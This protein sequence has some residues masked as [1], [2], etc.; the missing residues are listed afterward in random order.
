ME[1][2]LDYSKWRAGGGSMQHKNENM[3][4][5]GRTALLN[6]FGFMCCLGQ[7]SLQ[8]GFFEDDIKNSD[9]PA[10]L[11][12]ERGKLMEHFTYYD[13]LHMNYKNTELSNDLM[14]INDDL[15]TTYLQ[16]IDL[17]SA[18]LKEH[19]ITLTVINLP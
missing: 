14:Q 7:F 4:G 17:I 18:K 10:E 12:N 11:S 1:L 9:E 19:N 5:R 16:K 8:C 6:T 2:I 3:I 15:D 13:D